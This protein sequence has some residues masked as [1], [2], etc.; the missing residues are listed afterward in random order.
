[1]SPLWTR[2]PL[3]SSIDF[4]HV[5]DTRYVRPPLNRFVSFADSP[6]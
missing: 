6:L 3:A 2:M 4:D 1:M 5:Y